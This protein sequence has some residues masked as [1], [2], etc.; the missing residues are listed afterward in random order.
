MSKG[1][2][3]ILNKIKIDMDK[4]IDNM[5]NASAST[6]DSETSKVN[7]QFKRR[8]DM[9]TLKADYRHHWCERVSFE[10]CDAAKP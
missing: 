8:P 3:S 7:Y 6:K 4:H 5:A 10:I 1:Y 9:P 2:V